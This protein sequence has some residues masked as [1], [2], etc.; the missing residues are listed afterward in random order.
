[1]FRVG[2]MSCGAGREI[3]EGMD[4]GGGEGGQAEEEEARKKTSFEGEPRWRSAEFHGEEASAEFHAAT[5]R[6]QNGRIRFLKPD[7]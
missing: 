3:G 4:D 2:S 5:E 7:L 6:L 1:M